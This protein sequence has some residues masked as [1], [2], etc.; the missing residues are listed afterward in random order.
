ML[1]ASMG[2]K[3][4]IASSAKD[5]AS[6]NTTSKEA[7]ARNAAPVLEHCRRDR[8]A[9]ITGGG[10]SAKTVV[11][12]RFVTMADRDV[13]VRNVEVLLSANTTGNEVFVASA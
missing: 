8:S 13:S 2:K 3:E 11:D 4:G 9:L 7:N 12:L 1:D 10:Q 5:P 6:V